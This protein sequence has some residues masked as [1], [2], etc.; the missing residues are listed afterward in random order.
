MIPICCDNMTALDRFN[1]SANLPAISLASIISEDKPCSP[2]KALPISWESSL[3]E[4]ASI[5]SAKALKRDLD[6][7]D[8][9]LNKA[10]RNVLQ[11]LFS[12]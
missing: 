3:P 11:N 8:V 5:L 10:Q 7:D 6:D 2:Y 4:V 9:Y 12:T 1:F